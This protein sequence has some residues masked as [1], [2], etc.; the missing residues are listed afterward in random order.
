M[1]VHIALDKS[2]EAALGDF[3]IGTT[4]RGIGPGL[5]G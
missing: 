3:K 4:S 5:R 1:D 2:R